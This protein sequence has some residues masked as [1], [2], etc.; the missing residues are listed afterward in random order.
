VLV[1]GAVVGTIA[2]LL[3][4]P[5][6]NLITKD[7]TVI[8]Y[9]VRRALIVCPTYFLCGLMEVGSYTLRSLGKSTES[10]LICLFGSAVFRII[11]VNLTYEL[12]KS[13]ELVYASYPISW[14]ITTIVLFICVFS[15]LKKIKRKFETEN[16]KIEVIHIEKSE[17]HGN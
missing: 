6:V 10:M 5:I 7:Q 1:L 8:E 16:A 12:Y 17:P 3:S 9:A 13:Y 14:A 15:M 4:G 11:W 2:T